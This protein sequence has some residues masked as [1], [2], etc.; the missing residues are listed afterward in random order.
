GR[1]W[2]AWYDPKT[3]KLTKHI[4]IART[5]LQITN[6]AT[7]SRGEIFVCCDATGI[8]RLIPNVPAQSAAPDSPFPKKLSETGLFQDTQNHIPHP[9]LIPYDVNSPLWS[10]HAKKDR[11]I[12]LPGTEAIS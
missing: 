9:G 8:H 7:D 10:D 6:F 3:D 11:Y 4:E 12:A 2:A 1:V 5:G